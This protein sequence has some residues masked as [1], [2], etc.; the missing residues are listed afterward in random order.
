MIAFIYMPA[1]TIGYHKNP[2]TVSLRHLICVRMGKLISLVFPSQC[3][4]RTFFA[5]SLGDLVLTFAFVPILWKFPAFLQRVVSR[6]RCSLTPRLPS[7]R[8]VKLLSVYLPLLSAHYAFDCI[9]FRVMFFRLLF[10]DESP[11]K[12]KVLKHL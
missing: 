11:R 6:Y 3:E 2:L 12:Q 1:V 4:A 9:H 10:I 7:I 8:A 5:G